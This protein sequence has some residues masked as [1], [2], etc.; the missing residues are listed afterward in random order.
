MVKGDYTFPTTREY[1]KVFEIQLM[2]RL[3]K[4]HSDV[5]IRKYPRYSMTS[6]F[7]RISP[8]VPVTR[9]TAPERAP[10]IRAAL[11]K[12]IE[13]EKRP[14]IDPSKMK[15][16]VEDRGDN[17]VLYDEP[18]GVIFYHSPTG[19]CQIFSICNFNILVSLYIT[20]ERIRRQIE[21][22]ND[23]YISK[24]QV[25][26]DIEEKLLDITKKVFEND[27]E[28]Y[29]TPY[30]SSNGSEMVSCLFKIIEGDEEDF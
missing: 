25:M 4:P 14:D 16:F 19:N 2:A 22:V 13:E 24:A 30:R 17:P 5:V 8:P 23:Y 21:I 3:G 12:K 6:L 9:P 28:V 15:N 26:I 11:K 29:I 18:T 7:D 20:P 27:E 1:N 10:T